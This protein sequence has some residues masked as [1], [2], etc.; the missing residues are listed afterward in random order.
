MVSAADWVPPLSE[1]EMFAVVVVDTAD[2]LTVKVALV[3]PA[4]T[5]T[6]AG[7]VALAESDASVTTEPPGPA[8]PLSVTVPVDEEPPVRLAGESVRLVSVAG[9]MVRVAV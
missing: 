6:D 8:G 7:K 4:A 2:V 1:P 3:A 5:V 9:E